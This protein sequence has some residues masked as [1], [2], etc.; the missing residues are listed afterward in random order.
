MN[1]ETILDQVDI[2]CIAW[3]ASNFLFPPTLTLCGATVFQPPYRVISSI[4]CQ[5]A[6]D[7]SFAS[8]HPSICASESI[9]AFCIRPFDAS[10]LFHFAV[11]WRFIRACFVFKRLLWFQML[12][13][14]FQTGLHNLFSSVFVASFIGIIV[15]WWGCLSPLI[16]LDTILIRSNS[17]NPA[18]QKGIISSAFNRR[19]ELNKKVL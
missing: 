12:L 18:M 9:R 16:N 2:H 15:P 17:N 1:V 3:N 5:S 6:F 10:N 14:C 7:L 4:L 19:R 13:W 8:E 11:F